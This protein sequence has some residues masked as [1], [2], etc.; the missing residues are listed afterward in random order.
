MN[1]IRSYILIVLA[2]ACSVSAVAQL[3]ESVWVLGGDKFL[4]KGFRKWKFDLVLDGRNTFD[5]GNPVRIAGLRMGMEYKR[6]HRFGI[7]F[8]GLSELSRDNF[9]SSEGEFVPA[10]LKFD[11]NSIYYE[12]VL[13]FSKR[14]EVSGTA[15]FG[16]GQIKVSYDNPKE[17]GVTVIEDP[18]EARIMELSASTYFHLTWW[19]SIGAGV[20]HRWTGQTPSELG[21]IYDSTV[22]LAKAKL[23]FGKMLRAIRNKEVKYEY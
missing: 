19:F 23:R 17:T 2:T 16:A 10:K 1:S 9:Q 5:D 7:G 8:Y 6:V 4:G 14:W 20:G 21:N 18:I 3:N 11:Y 22:Y 15:H 12:R 13:F